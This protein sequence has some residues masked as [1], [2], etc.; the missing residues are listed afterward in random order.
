[1]K[2][3]VIEIT[4]GKVSNVIAETKIYASENNTS[5][6]DDTLESALYSEEQKK[7]FKQSVIC[8]IHRGIDTLLNE[9]P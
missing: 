5:I 2:K 4:I 1:M 9:K 7:N 3:F 6:I 8:A